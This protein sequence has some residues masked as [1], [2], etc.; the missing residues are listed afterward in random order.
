[1]ITHDERS[2]TLT[3]HTRRTTYQM[4][5]DE[6][7]A[8][9]HCY[10]GPRVGEG[11]L[12]Y[13]IQYADRGF[14]PNPNEAGHRRD[15]SL[16]T[17]PQEYSGCGV[18]DFRLPAAE[19]ELPD[20][21]RLLDLRYAGHEIRQGKYAL[22]GLPAFHGEGGETL[23]VRLRDAASGVEV[24]LLYGVFE[25][26]DLITRAARITNGGAAAVSLC[27]AMSLCLDFSRADLDLITFDG[28]HAQE[29]N[30]NRAPLRPGVQG[31]GS[32]RGMS[33]HQHNPF[34][35]LC[36]RDAGEDH[37]LCYGAALL[38]SGDFLAEA[39]RS[40]FDDTRLILGI[41]P[42]NF[43]W[44]L[45]PGES[46]STPETALACSP[47]GLARLTHCLHRAV[48][49]RLIRDP[50]RGRRRP[51]LVNNWE[52]T[53]FDFN[54]EKLA[55]L[56]EVSAGLG[57]ELFVMDDGWFGQRSDDM[58]GLGDWT[59]NREKLPSGLEGLVP[60]I[61]KLG[62]QFGIWVEPEMV[63][64]DSQLYRQH[65]DW[66]LAVPGRPP[67]RGR[68]QLTLDFGR[69]EVREYIYAAL[70]K[71][72][73][74]AEISY[75]KWDMNRSLTD[76]WSAALPPQ[77]QGE[78]CH[79]YTLGVYE[80]LERLRMDYPGL[81]IEGCAGGGG[82]FD[83]GMLYYTPQIWCSDNTDAIDR[84][85]IQ[86]GTSFCYPAGCMGSHV[87]VSPNEQNGR[88]TPL[89]TR[90]VVAMSGAFGYEMDLG[91]CPEA[92]KSLIKEQISTFKRHWQLIQEGDYYRLTDPFQ[93]PDCTAWQYVSQ[94]QRQSL[95]SLVT[96]SARASLPFRTLRLKGLDPARKYRV[97]GGE[98]LYG[99]DQLLYGGYPI[100]PLWGDYQ[101]IQLYLEAAESLLTERI[102][103]CQ[104][105]RTN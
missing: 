57:A 77:R 75:V 93:A 31:V 23:S 12:S 105:I 49:E 25:D 15:Y 10:Y 102:T 36:E 54:E 72:L 46:F 43:R 50:Y 56:A 9:L 62:M 69:Q 6:Y 13:L 40:Q 17:L 37:G 24:E 39:E 73:D 1:M 28:G 5:V 32:T 30:L 80:L 21:S 101:S 45:A 53:Y 95:V 60:R 97:N 90:G 76:L 74:S 16:D 92:E 34:V 4:K 63:S 82:R 52:A 100:P 99:G 35:I 38:Y 91:K 96:G 11:D 20:G 86:Y 18:G 85:R 103:G 51:V 58:R 44:P 79:R 27:R 65:P 64:E 66:A 61:Q 84:L 94:D 22:P 19:V 83:L 14:S 41:H 29:R 42:R 26:F 70:R 98:A 88:I 2:H 7:R 33:S 67:A 89:E 68:S 59:V 81:L 55:A 104:P 47:D 71:V 8:L 48:R 78:V 87:S 3:L